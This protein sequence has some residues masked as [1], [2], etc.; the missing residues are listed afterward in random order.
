MVWA[1][2]N[3]IIILILGGNHILIRYL[4]VG[5]STALLELLLFLCLHRILGLAIAGAN[6]SAMVVATG[7]NFLFNRNWSFR[8]KG[9]ISQSF[10]LYISLILFNM[11]FL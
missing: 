3:N 5:G 10:I 1:I 9:K 7:V 4:I 2:L 11:V 8:S 6:I